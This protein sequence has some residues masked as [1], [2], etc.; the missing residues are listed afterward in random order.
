MS[1]PWHCVSMRLANGWA[2]V[3]TSPPKRHVTNV[4]SPSAPEVIAS[5]AICTGRAY[6]WL[7]LM[8]KN[9]PRSSASRNSR[10]A[11]SRSNTSGF[12]TSNG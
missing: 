4:M 9:R 3:P 5:W 12:S 7:K 11:S 2:L 10:S 8:A 6:R 1:K